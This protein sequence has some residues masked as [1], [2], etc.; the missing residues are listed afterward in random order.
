MRRNIVFGEHTIIHGYSL[1][2]DARQCQH[3][4]NSDKGFAVEVFEDQCW[5]SVHTNNVYNILAD[6]SFDMIFRKMNKGQIKSFTQMNFPTRFL[7]DKSLEGNL[8]AA[9]KAHSDANMDSAEN[10]RYH[11]FLRNRFITASHDGEPMQSDVQQQ[12]VIRISRK[13]IDRNYVDYP[14]RSFKSYGSIDWLSAFGDAFNLSKSYF[15]E[16]S[17]R[18]RNELKNVVMDIVFEGGVGAIAIHEACGHLVE[19]DLLTSYSPFFNRRNEKITGDFVTLVD[20]P[21]IPGALGSY[22]VDDEGRKAQA[23]TVIE[24]GRFKGFLSSM[25]YSNGDDGQTSANG[26][27]CSYRDRAYPRMSNLVLLPGKMSRSGIIRSVARGLLVRRIG[28]GGESY[29]RLG[30]FSLSVRDGRYIAD[31]KVGEPT[32]RLIVHGNSIDFLKGIASVGRKPVYKPLATLC[33]KHQQRLYTDGIAPPFLVRNID[34][35]WGSND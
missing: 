15:S 28:V 20:D 21:S 6:T 17:A 10:Y 25:R 24:K 3:W 30:S 4:I 14:V 9:F 7:P 16:S 33:E 12:I 13:K 22:S 18:R 35:T 8:Y 2:P 11:L 26:R 32:G 23:T 5:R 1:S 29:P 34:V 31:G 19:A 27:R